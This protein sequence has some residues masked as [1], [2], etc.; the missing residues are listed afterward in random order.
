MVLSPISRYSLF[1]R[2]FEA[3]LLPFVPGFM[4]PGGYFLLRTAP[5]VGPEP[6]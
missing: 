6:G 3:F 1:Y 4:L 5:T 2:G